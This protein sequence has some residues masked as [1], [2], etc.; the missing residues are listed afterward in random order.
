MKAMIT[1][2]GQDKPGIIAKVSAAVFQQKANILDI[3]Q[4][5][6]RDEFFAMI[7]LV[8]LEENY[9]ELQKEMETCAKEI[10]M[11]IKMQREEIFRSMHRI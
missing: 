6:M 10:G 9:A 7:M 2:M 1:V 11:E 4:T 5:V 3:T 8:E